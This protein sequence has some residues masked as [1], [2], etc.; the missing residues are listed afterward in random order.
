M[1]VNALN[2]LNARIISLLFI[3]LI[4]ILVS[5]P[6]FAGLGTSVTLVSGQPTSINP[7]EDTQLEITLSNNNPAAAITGV[8]FSNNLPGTLPDGLEI[9]GAATYT[10]TDASVPSTGPG[11]GTLT[12]TI[13]T[14]AITLTGGIIPARDTASSTDGVCTIIIPVTA[15]S[16]SGAPATHNYQ[17]A[18]GAVTGNDGVAVANSGAVNQSINVLGV[19]LP[20]VS[21]SFASSTLVL[22]GAPTTLTITVTNPNTTIAIPNFS[23]TDNFPLLGGSSILQVAS[24]PS[25]T[26]TCTGGGTPATF[27]PVAGAVSVSATGGT[28]TALLLVD[29]MTLMT[30]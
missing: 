21:K 12:V 23:V 1:F 13:G 8:A 17:I 4:T 2:L 20:V 11:A 9:S 16:S 3:C 26:T 6:S 18:N 27:T 7:G 19:S 30:V 5:S 10:C 28:V 29:I 25:A 15:G 24:P 14:Q 22:G